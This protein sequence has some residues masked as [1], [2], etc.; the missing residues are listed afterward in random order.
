MHDDGASAYVPAGHAEAEK[1]QL[2]APAELKVFEEHCEQGGRPPTPKV[3]LRQG[4]VSANTVGVLAPQ[5]ELYVTNVRD[6]PEEKGGG[7]ALPGFA[8]NMEVAVELAL[9]PLKMENGPSLLQ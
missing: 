2:S 8:R 6:P 3:P 4:R 5:P 9:G 1:S 7:N